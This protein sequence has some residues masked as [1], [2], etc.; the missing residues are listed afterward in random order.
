M[1][2]SSATDGL[3]VVELADEVVAAL[4]GGPA[5]ERVGLELHGA[6]A[7]DHAAALMARFELL[8]KVGCVG[9]GWLL[10]DLQE[11]RVFG[12]IALH[13]DAVVAQANGAGADDLEGDIERGVLGEEVPALGL[14]ALGIGGERVE[15]LARSGAVDTGEVGWGGFEDCGLWN[16]ARVAPAPRRRSVCREPRRRER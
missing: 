15:H 7:V 4:D 3:V 5:E 1:S 6:L 10:L 13:V 11:E 14:Q 12:A 2:W 16:R 8:A 9:G